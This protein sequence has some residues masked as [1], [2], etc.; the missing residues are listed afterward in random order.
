M[1]IVQR[2]GMIGAPVTLM[3]AMT[4]TFYR[5]YTELIDAYY[6]DIDLATECAAKPKPAE[7]LP[8]PPAL[9]G[10]PV[11]E[12]SMLNALQI[13]H[14][15]LDAGHLART[16]AVLLLCRMYATRDQ[17]RKSGRFPIVVAFERRYEALLRAYYPDLDAAECR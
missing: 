2:C 16:Q 17:S 10:E 5:R 4:R 13:I 12:G 1:A 3:P 7:R 15:Q 6:P 8:L 14:E 11:L 9:A